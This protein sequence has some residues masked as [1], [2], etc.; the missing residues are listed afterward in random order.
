M[1][2]NPLINPAGDTCVHCG[3]PTVRNFGSFDTL[4]LVEFVPIGNLPEKRVLEALKM[5]PPED[6]DVGPAPAR[7]AK[8]KAGPDGWN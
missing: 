2:I 4:P 5:D 1:N 6:G 8:K 7:K 3:Q